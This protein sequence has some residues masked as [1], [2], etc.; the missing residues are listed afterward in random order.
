MLV[1][2]GQLIISPWESMKTV[3]MMNFGMGINR[4]DRCKI[5]VRIISIVLF[6]AKWHIKFA[7]GD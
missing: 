1:R 5:V 7:V 2:E 6:G 3:V 4:S